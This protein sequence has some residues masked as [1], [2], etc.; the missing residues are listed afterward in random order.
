[1]A[2]RGWP[3]G[4][5]PDGGELRRRAR[6]N[7]GRDQS[8]PRPG[9]RDALIER[10]FKVHAINP[11]EMDYLGDDFT[12]AGAKDDSRDAEVLASAL[13][14]VPRCFRPLAAADPVMV[15]LREWSLFAEDLGVERKR[16]VNRLREPLWRYCLA[17]LGLEGDLSAEWLFGELW[18]ARADA[19]Y[20]EP[21]ARGDD[22]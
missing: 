8:P 18:E 6:S 5:R 7:P 1:M 13:R 12:M 9:I 20:G 15:E 2:A 3:D 22:R 14:T 16:V 17:L 21:S 19:G 10:G 11:R 4:G